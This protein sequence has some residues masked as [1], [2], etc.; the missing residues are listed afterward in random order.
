MLQY[1]RHTMLCLLLVS[2]RV[3]KLWHVCKASI[4]CFGFICCGSYC[5]MWCKVP[6]A[7]Y[8]VLVT[9]LSVTYTDFCGYG[10]DTDFCGRNKERK[11]II[12]GLS[13]IHTHFC[14]YVS[15]D[16]LIHPWLFFG[17][18]NFQISICLYL[19][20]QSLFMFKFCL[21]FMFKFLCMSFA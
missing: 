1:R 8:C 16:F 20:S 3:V 2:T 5:R 10:S 7:E 11:G 15:P 21:I 9:G 17:F 12:L 4:F 6:C 19:N 14:A 18:I 13:I